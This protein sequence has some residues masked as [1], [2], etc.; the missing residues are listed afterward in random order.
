MLNGE[1]GEGV[2][3]IGRHRPYGLIT[4]H[5]MKV[6]LFLLDAFLV[7]QQPDHENLS[8]L[9]YRV[10]FIKIDAN[11]PQKLATKFGECI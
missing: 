4:I 10:N 6:I 1:I 8:I 5:D 2:Q 9:F 11:L 7:N 3:E